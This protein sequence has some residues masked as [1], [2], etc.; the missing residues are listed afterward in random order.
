MPAEKMFF[1]SIQ[2]I[3]VHMDEGAAAFTF[4]VKM[5]PAFF[6]LINILI[7]GTFI[8]KPDIFANLPRGPQFLKMTVDGGLPDSVFRVLK[9]AYYLINRY[10]P[11]LKGSH[12]IKNALSLPGMIIRRTFICHK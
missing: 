10:M 1:H 6:F 11:A 2:K 9:M 3:A 4:Q 12:I 7:T 8:I 5:F